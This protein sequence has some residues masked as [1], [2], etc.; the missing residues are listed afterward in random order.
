M[1]R[2]TTTILILLFDSDSLPDSSTKGIMHRLGSTVSSCISSSD[3]CGNILSRLPSIGVIASP[4]RLTVSDIDHM[5]ISVIRDIVPLPVLIF[6]SFA[7]LAAETARDHL[8][9]AAVLSLLNTLYATDC[10]VCEPL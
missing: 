10:G 3:V 4:G 2:A 6:I 7:Y 8:P 9:V 5:A 1:A